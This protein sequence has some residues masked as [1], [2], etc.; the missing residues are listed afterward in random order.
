MGRF[1]QLL[2]ALPD[3]AARFRAMRAARRAPARPETWGMQA[4]EAGHLR[5]GGCDCAALADE[6]ATPLHVSDA[7]LL[8]DAHAKFSA[9]FEGH[10]GS[11][12]VFY[13][14]KA[15]PVPAILDV[16]HAA[17]AG[18][19]VM[20]PHELWLALENGV[21]PDRIVYNGPGKD[22]AGL[23][24]AVERGIRRIHLDSLREL[25][26]VEALAEELEC[27][28]A[29]GLRLSPDTSWATA[30]GF[31]PESGDV[32]QA[33]ERLARSR[34]AKFDAVH[35]HI[36]SLIRTAAPYQRSAEA[37]IGFLAMARREFGLEASTLSLGG[38]FGLPTVRVQDRTDRLLQRL[39][40]TQAVASAGRV[41]SLPELASKVLDTLRASCRAHGIEVP[42]L[43][44]EPGRALTSAAQVLLT[45]VRDVKT[46]GRKPAIAVLDA[47]MANAF[48]ATWEV[49]V[50]LPATKL[51]QAFT[52]P[53][54]LIGPTCTPADQ[55]AS[56]VRLPTLEPGD[57]IA[58]MDAGAYF[59]TFEST[60]GQ[61]RPAVVLVDEGNPRLVRSRERSQDVVARDGNAPR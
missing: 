25:E 38:G 3:A 17:G 32:R 7:A 1:L 6:H 16:L 13:A 29:V 19:E 59:T 28:Q 14:Y 36:G 4:D 52:T 10:A 44:L 33:L 9:A 37:L 45:R 31:G 48:A 34:H 50:F 51:D 47:G 54:R 46:A 56:C 21:R 61:P 42:A 20:S 26:R 35:A 27:V 49:H 40:R 24:V 30:F 57:L 8:W 18:A 43:E 41:D 11:C 39:L 53:Y 5:V 60:F 12:D 58:I 55:L 15:N 22:E 2:R 23:R